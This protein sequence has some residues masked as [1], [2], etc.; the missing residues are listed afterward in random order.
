[1][2]NESKNECV[3]RKVPEIM[4]DDPS[5]DQE[6]AVAIAENVCSTMCSDKQAIGLIKGEELRTKYIDV[7]NK[8]IDQRA[9]KLKSNLNGAANKEEQSLLQVIHSLDLTKGTKALGKDAKKAINNFYKEQRGVMAEFVLPFITEY[10]KEA[11]VEALAGLNP[12]KGF[13][14]TAVIQKAL[15]KR[16]KQFGLGVSNTTRDH[17]T[18]AIRAG[19][20]AGEGM[21]QISDR[22]AAVYDEFPTWRSDLIARTE[23]T[24]ANNEGFIEAFKQSDV[25]THKE[26]IATMDDRTRDEHADLN[27]DIVPVGSTFANGLMYPE[28]PNCRCVIG[29][30]FVD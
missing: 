16:A 8:Q 7:I 29:P 2:D 19:L 28:E 10:L 15:E 9:D 18:Q 3:S 20:G 17:I 30:A 4:A 21:T 13:E 14:L 24:A 1:M 26:W 23:S 25:A 12:D 6:Q 22:I 5:I 11:G 27:G